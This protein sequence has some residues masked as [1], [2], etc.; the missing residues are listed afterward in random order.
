MSF[1][2]ILGHIKTPKCQWSTELKEKAA[3]FW[4]ATMVVRCRVLPEEAAYF[5][6]WQNMESNSIFS[7][8]QKKN[9]MR[10]SLES[11]VTARWVQRWGEKSSPQMQTA[12]GTDCEELHFAKS[13]LL[14][15]AVT[16]SA[17]SVCSDFAHWKCL[18]GK[19]AS[20]I[21]FTNVTT[22]I[23]SC[24]FAVTSFF[25]FFFSARPYKTVSIRVKLLYPY[26]IHIFI[27]SVSRH[28]SRFFTD[29]FMTRSL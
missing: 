4:F 7:G 22:E 20:D 11:R 16:M 15:H 29:S 23:C 8:G 17:A 27:H 10:M 13:R 28:R 1:L 2:L 21:F 6:I 9:E 18:S 19:S 3:L 12:Q 14:S 26:R 5:W 24:V 25:L